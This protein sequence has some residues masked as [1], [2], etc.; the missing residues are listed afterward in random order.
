VA[1]ER[2]VQ[3]RRPSR[4]NLLPRRDLT[5]LADRLMI[6]QEEQLRQVSRELHEEIGQSLTAVSSY[7]W[8]LQQQVPSQPP[9]LR[10]RATEARRLVGRILGELRELSQLLR[11]RALDLY[12]LIPSLEAHLRT[13]EKRHG[14]AAELFVSDV[15]ERLPPET[16][17]A[18]YRITQEALTN[19]ARHA[20]AT[21]VWVALT[22]ISG[23]LRLKIEDNGDGLP[24][25]GSG[26]REGVGLIGIRE[27]ART[28]GGTTAL[29]SSRGVRLSVHLPLDG[30]SRQV[31]R[32]PRSI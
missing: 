9:T 15:P 16:E 32:G 8:V 2:S 18:L 17:T 19:V 5:A 28:L 7:L 12:G 23:E 20:R 27:R 6:V 29:T 22:V 26:R 30:P 24:Q 25:D 10:A 3:A 1:V 21:R 13:F 11:P 14:I 31:A 4:Q